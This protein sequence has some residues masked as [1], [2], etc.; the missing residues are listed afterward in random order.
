M[1]SKGQVTL[2][3]RFAPGTVVR[4][5][6]VKDESVLRAEGGQE[7]AT[8]T[9]DDDGVVKFT[10]GVEAG[11]RYLICG[12]DRGDYREVRVR[13]NTADE[14]SAVLTQAPVGNVETRLSGGAKV[15]RFGRV[16]APDREK[17]PGPEVAPGPGQHQVAEGTVQ[18]SDTPLGIAT[19][20][21]T[22]EVLPHPKQEDVNGPVQRSDTETG[23]ATPIPP[24]HPERQEDVTKG[25]LLQRSDTELGV[26]TPIPAADAVEAKLEQDSSEAKAERGEPVK[27]AARTTDKPAGK[28]RTRKP[29]AKKTSA[30]RKPATKKTSAQAKSGATN[31]SRR[32]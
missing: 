20:V 10:S 16:E 7:V 32:K 6:K 9:V 11:G 8:G 28:P 29:A 26:T 30:A 27:V 19:P 22:D 5:V 18:R 21:D 15:D 31:T 17:T 3:G 14:E 23:Q 13:G 24:A 2:H 12:H 1:A 25:E 4:L